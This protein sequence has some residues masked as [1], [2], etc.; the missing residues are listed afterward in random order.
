MDPQLIKRMA[1]EAGMV[2][3]PYAN[4]STERI[5]QENREFPDALE[6]FAEMVVKE[7]V[8]VAIENERVLSKAAY[9]SV[10]SLLLSVQNDCI[11]AR[12]RADEAEAELSRKNAVYDAAEYILDGMGIDAPDYVIDPDD[13]FLDAAVSDWVTDTLTR[14]AAAMKVANSD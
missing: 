2:E 5:W 1:K 7:C 14:L 3:G 4:G 9:D 6:M 11:A 13:D 10:S 12:K 8:D